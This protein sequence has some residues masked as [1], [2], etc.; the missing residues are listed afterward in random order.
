[1]KDFIFLLSIALLN[2]MAGGQLMYRPYPIVQW[3]LRVKP[4]RRGNGVFLSPDDRIVVA[5][6]NVGKL[7]ALDAMDGGALWSYS[8]SDEYQGRYGCTSGVTFSVAGDF[9]VYAVIVDELSPNPFSRV[10]AVSVYGEELWVSDDFE[11][12][13]SGTPVLSEDGNFVFFNYNSNRETVGHFTILEAFNGTTFHEEGYHAPFAPL[14]IHHAPG[15]GYYD[16][17][18]FNRQDILVWSVQPK[19]LDE[20]VGDGKTFAFQFPIVFDGVTS[21][22][23]NYTELGT[24]VRDFQAIQK[25]VF[26]NEGRSLYLGTS[27]YSTIFSL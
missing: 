5:S 26:A 24:A 1:M 3:S 25:P 9:L 23:L 21:Y 4:V 16:G 13:V 12:I 2:G 17:G 8:P 18:Q 22:G 6:T 19:P 7:E 15:E 14:G 27:S 20:E 11:G 10:I